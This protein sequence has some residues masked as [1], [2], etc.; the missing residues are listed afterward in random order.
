ILSGFYLNTTKL[1]GTRGGAAFGGRI[2][3][4]NDPVNVRISV[5]EVQDGY[6]PAVGFIDRRGY[7]LV[8]PG[9]RYIV[10]IK[11]NPVIRRFSLEADVNSIYYLNGT[12][13]TRTTDFQLIRVELQSSDML[14]FHLRP[15]HERL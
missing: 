11:N 9:L 2:N 13:E 10:H 12:L 7:R 8:D 5:R 1:P 15:L 3:L 14:E 6:D 4:P